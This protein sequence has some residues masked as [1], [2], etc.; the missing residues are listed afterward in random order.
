MKIK[1]SIYVIVFLICICGNAKEFDLKLERT[2]GDERK[3]YT[4]FDISSAVVSE[5][6][7]IYVSDRKGHFIAFPIMVKLTVFYSRSSNSLKL[8]TDIFRFPASISFTIFTH[9]S[10]MGTGTFF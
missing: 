7:D 2:I 8:S 4:F 3:D 6:K 10:L 9:F 1:R 5:D